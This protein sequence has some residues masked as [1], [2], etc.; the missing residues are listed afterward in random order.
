MESNDSI[1]DPLSYSPDDDMKY[2]IDI[3]TLSEMTSNQ[4]DSADKTET[5]PPKYKCAKCLAQ[6]ALRVDYKVVSLNPPR[7]AG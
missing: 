4:L 2:K 3:N 5:K 6:F 1:D 7:I